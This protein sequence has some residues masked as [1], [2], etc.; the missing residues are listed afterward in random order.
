MYIYA[1]IYICRHVL[2]TQPS[3]IKILL[4]SPSRLRHLAHDSCL[5]TLS[6]WGPGFRGLELPAGCVGTRSRLNAPAAALQRAPDPMPTPGDP[7]NTHGTREALQGS[8]GFPW[9]D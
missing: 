8:Y 4:S 9:K 5:I 6:G 3:N 7:T 1:Y 2:H